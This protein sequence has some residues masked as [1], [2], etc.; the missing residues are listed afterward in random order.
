MIQN[1]VVQLDGIRFI[2]VFMIFCAHWV[3]GE[4]TNLIL[5]EIPL[6]HGVTLFFVLSGYL[7]T[8]SLFV[9]QDKNISRYK[10]VQFFY[11]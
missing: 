3:Q 5:L 9:N 2:A 1:R 6:V 8:H 4:L 7:I 10:I 11:T